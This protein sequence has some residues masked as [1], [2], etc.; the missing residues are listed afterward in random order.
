MMGIVFNKIYFKATA[1]PTAARTSIFFDEKNCF[2]KIL[3]KATA[4]PTSARTLN[5]FHH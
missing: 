1:A 4:A 5:F 3:F 2:N